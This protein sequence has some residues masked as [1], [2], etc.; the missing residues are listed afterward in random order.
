MSEQNH[1]GVELCGA[2]E[3]AERGTAVGFEVRLRDESVPAFALRFDGQA[4]AYL[5]RCAHIP[6]EMDWRPGQFLDDSGDWII[7]AMHGAMY[8]PRDGSCVGGPCGGRGLTR[9]EVGER[10]GK[11]YWYPSPD[12][13]PVFD[14]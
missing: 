1:D 2:E 8:D 6:V 4:V 12:I 5:N 7:C 13:R 14:E 9:I 10:D 3:L 11:V